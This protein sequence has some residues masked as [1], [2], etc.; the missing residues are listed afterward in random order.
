[1]ERVVAVIALGA[2]LA[3]PRFQAAGAQAL[4][5]NTISWPS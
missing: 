1:V 5:H 4:A 2:D 3:Q